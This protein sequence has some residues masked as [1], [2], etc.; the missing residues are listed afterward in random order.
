MSYFSRKRLKARMAFLITAL[1]A[2]MLV[3]SACGDSATNTPA[4][5]SA[6]TAASSATTAAGSAATT[7][8]A[9]ANPALAKN[10]TLTL[11]AT[12][13]E[14]EAK[15]LAAAADA[16]NAKYPSVKVQVQPVSWDDAHAKML[17]AATSGVGPDLMTGGL[18]WGIE[19]GQKG[20]MVDLKEKFPTV[21]QDVEKVVHPQIYKSVVSTD[22]KVY[23]VPWDLTIYQ[24]FYRTDLM[25]DLT[26]SN[27]PPKNWDELTAAIQ[28]AQTSGKKGFAMQWGNTQW[29]QY[30]NYLYQAGGTLY[31][32][33]CTKATINS[34]EG[35]KALQFYADLYNK[36]KAPTDGSPD[37][38]SGL[39]TG[40]YP[41]G[42]SGSWI[43]GGLDASKPSIKGKW[44]LSPLPAGPSGKR[45]GF[46]G[47]RVIGIMGGS[48]NQAA[49]SEFIRFIYTEGAVDAMTKKAS[50]VSIF[51]IP[52]R[53]DFVTKIQAPS[54][55]IESVKAQLNDSVGPPNC[56]GWEESARVVEQKL[57]EAIFK[58]GDAKKL[59]DE[60]AAAMNQNLKP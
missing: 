22:K 24:M 17:A 2:A 21:V 51:Y 29:L 59:L 32:E 15:V 37:L 1:L 45:T 54:D 10:A 47:G 12:G 7:A 14:D 25:K 18:S 39:E 26:G 50:E 48:K 34:P 35:V 16:F 44:S 58:Q 27:N 6:T 42:S 52:P 46:I 4:A 56:T 60:A 33:G 36:Y 9:T 41:F 53:V 55:R 8:A 13:S 57:Q 38:E 20:G 31:D 30:F 23:G 49:A 40:D 11:W 3:L 28:K 5:S 19:F 43:S